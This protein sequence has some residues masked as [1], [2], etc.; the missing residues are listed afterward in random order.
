MSYVQSM[1]NKNLYLNLSAD[2][3]GSSLCLVHNV[4][5]DVNNSCFKGVGGGVHTGNLEQPSTWTRGPRPPG[6]KSS[7]ESIQRSWAQSYKKG[8]G[9]S[10]HQGHVALTSMMW[11]SVEGSTRTCCVLLWLNTCPGLKGSSLGM[12][13]PFCC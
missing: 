2:V 9:R 13:T 10:G 6:S 8:G 11:S 3:V 12:A 1:A 7:E 4:S 5:D